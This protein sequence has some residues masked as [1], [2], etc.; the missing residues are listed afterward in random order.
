MIKTISLLH[1][2]ADM[3]HDAFVERYEAVHVPLVNRLLG[4][5]MGYRRNFLVSG[6]S[7][8]LG[9]AQP[10]FDC[11]TAIRFENVDAL[12]ELGSRLAV[13]DAGTIITAD[14]ME[15][16]DRSKMA[17]FQVDE[18]AIIGP[19]PESLLP[20]PAGTRLILI[21]GKDPDIP[22]ES[23]VARCDEQ[24]TA[25]A[26]EVVRRDVGD[27]QSLVRNHIPPDGVFDLGHIEGHKAVVDFAVILEIMFSGAVDWNAFSNAAFPSGGFGLSSLCPV[28]SQAAVIGFAADERA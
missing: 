20:D 1:A 28:P 6:S 12:A 7:E 11:M 21:G 3:A 19:A 5:F 15:M 22:P 14:E 10:D 23:F 26:E 17:M 8:K 4:P 27:L 16:F 13:G 2:K 18:R 9:L 24:C 25:F